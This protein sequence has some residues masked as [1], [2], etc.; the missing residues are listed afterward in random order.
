MLGIIKSWFSTASCPTQAKKL[1]E[2]T[3]PASPSSR[4]QAEFKVQVQK[5]AS[6]I[7]DA[8]DQL[9]H[10]V[11]GV[12]TQVEQKVL[13]LSKADQDRHAKNMFTH[14]LRLSQ[15]DLAK[16][17]P[18]NIRTVVYYLADQAKSGNLSDADKAQVR[19]MFARFAMLS[20]EQF[21]RKRLLANQEALQCVLSPALEELVAAEAANPSLKD[22]AQHK[23]DVAIAKAQLVVA[24]GVPLTAAGGCNGAVIVKSFEGNALGVFKAVQQSTW[25]NDPTRKVKEWFGQARLFNRRDERNET[26]AEIVMADFSKQFGFNLAPEAKSVV[27]NDKE[28][29]FLAF[30]GG[31]KELADVQEALDKRQTFT[32]DEKIKVQ[33]AIVAAFASTNHD[34]HSGNIFVGMKNGEI[35]EV[36]LIDAGNCFAE[37]LPGEWGSKGHRSDPGNLR[38]SKEP[39]EP[40]VIEFIRSNLT[41]AKYD[42]FVAG[43]QARYPG[44]WTTKMDHL[45]RQTFKLLREHV[46]KD[47]MT[48]QE[49]MNLTTW[50]DFSKLLSQETPAAD[51]VETD[52]GWVLLD[53]DQ[54]TADKAKADLIVKQIA[55]VAAAERATITVAQPIVAAPLVNP[56][57]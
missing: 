3:K 35:D 25:L 22:D 46:G 7:K 18:D 50:K 14:Y 33:L 48:P 36:K 32:R 11:K 52:D 45:H 31:Y 54:E 17:S 10:N 44:F 9:E 38:I 1:P 30:L 16:R 34:P 12:V 43:V 28:G 53:I 4:V 39:F 27:L 49:L 21:D 51:T 5:T 19:T 23:L 29:S 6:K 41:D 26:R 57:A 56:V 55:N 13:K 24:M 15:L 2:A 37:R 40:E 42:E 20:P 8:A 47:I